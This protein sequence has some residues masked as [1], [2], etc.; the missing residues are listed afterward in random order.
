MS[1]RTKILQNMNAFIWTTIT[2]LLF[3]PAEVIVMVM[4]TSDMSRCICIFRDVVNHT[5]SMYKSMVWHLKRN[6]IAFAVEQMT[7]KEFT[8]EACGDFQPEQIFLKQKQQ[9]QKMTK[10]FMNMLQML[11]VCTTLAGLYSI[12]IRGGNGDIQRIPVI[13]HTKTQY[14]WILWMQVIPL[15]C[16]GYVIVCKC[17]T[18]NCK[19][20]TGLPIS[21]TV[22]LKITFILY[23][24]F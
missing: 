17:I 15:G 7:S 21:E 18:L 1:R 12:F 8:Y 16:F 3:Y 2:Y 4:N 23:L 5:G 14:F 13:G 9:L 24:S 19:I 22:Y 20:F 10:I 11:M 6:K